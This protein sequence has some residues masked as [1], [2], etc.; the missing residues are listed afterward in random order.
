MCRLFGLSGG[1]NRVRATFWLLEAPDS[2]ALQSR[3]EPDGTGLG[4]FDPDGSPRILRNP[5]AAYED[6]S[7]SRAAR[8]EESRTFVAHVRYASTG[9][10][11]V[12]NTH[13]FEQ[14]GRLFAHNGLIQD[15]GRLETRLGHHRSLALGDTDSE[16]YFALI[17]KEIE[18]SNG[19]VGAGIIEATRWIAAELPILSLNM[20]LTTPD[21]LWALRY[22]DIHHLFMLERASGGPYGGGTWSTPAPP[23]PCACVRR[24]SAPYHPSSSPRNAWTRIQVGSR[25]SQ[26]IFCT[27]ARIYHVP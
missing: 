11:S 23:V 26:E 8:E 3:K 19:D 20:V 16:R 24:T 5:V 4:Y 9:G 1:P 15:L 17:T 13:P 7:F 25:W 22:P 6:S 21:G 2:L 10:L 27:S 12:R 14:C 18:A